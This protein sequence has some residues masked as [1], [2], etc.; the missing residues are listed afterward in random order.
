[1]S[2]NILA[3]LLSFAMMLTGAGGE[4]Q[5]AQAATDGGPDARAEAGRVHGRR[6]G[7]V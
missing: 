3:I 6:E 4:G 5:P 2:L 1:M 7:R